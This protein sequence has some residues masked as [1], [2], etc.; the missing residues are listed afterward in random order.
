M[1]ERRKKAAPVPKPVFTERELQV[2]AL[3][4]KGQTHAEIADRLGI[5][6]HTLKEHTKH[7]RRK[8]G[9]NSRVQLAFWA[10]RELGM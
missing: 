9:V 10:I 1:K 4:A 7:C 2:L 3:I 5:S 8:A 6:V